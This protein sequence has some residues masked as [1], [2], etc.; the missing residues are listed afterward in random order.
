MDQWHADS[1]QPTRF[2][3]QA[4]SFLRTARAIR[5]IQALTAVL[6]RHA[7]QARSSQPMG[8]H[9]VAFARVGPILIILVRSQTIH[10]GPVQCN[11]LRS[12][13]AWKSQPAPAIQVAPGQMVV[14][15]WNAVQGNSSHLMAPCH[16]RLVQRI[17]PLQLEALTLASVMLDFPGP[18][19]GNAR[20][21]Q[22][23]A[24][25]PR[26]ALPHVRF[27]KSVNTRVMPRRRRVSTAHVIPFLAPGARI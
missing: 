6:A 18:T 24:T 2:R 17:L 21:V 12:P 5:D 9:H 11:P 26:M 15:V 7:L 16:A 23:G 19:A 3:K 27:A 25:R 10:A 1:V 20:H 8:L 13:A 14:S 22:Q 4:A